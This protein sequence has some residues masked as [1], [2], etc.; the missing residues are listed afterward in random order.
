MF[1]YLKKQ[2]VSTPLCR[3]LPKDFYNPSVIIGS[4]SFFSTPGMQKFHH[5]LGTLL[6]LIL[7]KSLSE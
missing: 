3:M 4:I 2:S 1:Q 7:Q 6:G 5:L